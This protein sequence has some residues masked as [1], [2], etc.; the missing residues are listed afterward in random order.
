VELGAWG[1]DDG[2]WDAL[3]RWHDAPQALLDHIASSL[4]AGSA[5]ATTARLPTPINGVGVPMFTLQNR[6]GDA[7]TPIDFTVTEGRAP[8]DND[9]IAIGPKTADDL[10]AG[11]GDTVKLGEGGATAHVVGIALFQPD[12]HAD[13]Y[14]GETVTT[15]TFDAV[16]PD[17]TMDELFNGPD[18]AVVVRFPK[19]GNVATEIASVRDGLGSPTTDVGPAEVPVELTNLANVRRMPILLAAFLGL[20]AAGAV[21]HVLFSS[22]QRRRRDFAVLRSVG[23]NR[24]G[25]RVVLNA[26]GS[27]IGLVGLVLG[28]P[29]GV[30]VGRSTWRWITEQVPLEFVPPFAVIAV[31]VVVP[32]T[33]I[34][35]N[36]FAL[37]P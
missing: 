23:V 37:W 3:G 29:L 7:A 1:I 11:I 26:Q 19:G 18:R 31:V 32:A 27:T 21:T 25:T 12:F 33:L 30:A 24:G 14:D 35:V 13:F 15:E 16:A 28:I 17:I 34:L 5:W 6:A 8:A 10:D 4:P 36:L 20:L 2:Y 9:E 22:S